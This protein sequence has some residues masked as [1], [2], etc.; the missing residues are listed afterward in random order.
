AG[1]GGRS[2]AAPDYGGLDALVVGAS[3]REGRVASYSSS[4]DRAK[5]GL[6]APGGSGSDKTQDAA[7]ENI[8]SAWW[9][10]RRPNRY[11]VG[12]GTSMAAPHVAGAAALL[13]SLGLGRDET[14]ARILDTA[15]DSIP[16]GPGCHGRLDLAR[17]V[18]RSAPTI[19]TE[20]AATT[21]PADANLSSNNKGPAAPATSSKPAPP[22]TPAI[23]RTPSKT[24]ASATAGPPGASGEPS[25]STTAAS[26]DETV[27]APLVLAFSPVAGAGD[28]GGAPLLPA[29]VLLLIAGLIAIGIGTGVQRRAKA[30]LGSGPGS[31]PTGAPHDLF[32][33]GSQ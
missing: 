15:D 13:L 6:V 4:L 30:L 31:R 1:N 20:P 16:C 32:R 2:G 7:S 22:P 27:R 28:G 8:V 25:S 14:V 33:S 17:A 19:V 26:G 21:T 12:A 9:D 29:P 3:D 11:A 5:W 18:A 24:P 23:T 10:P